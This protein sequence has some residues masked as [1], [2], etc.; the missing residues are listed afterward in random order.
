MRV[1]SGDKAE[2]ETML[3]LVAMASDLGRPL[4]GAI[5]N[6]GRVDGDSDMGSDIS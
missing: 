3:E 6:L 5:T 4:S 2:P 1:G